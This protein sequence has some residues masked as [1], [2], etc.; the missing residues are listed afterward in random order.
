MLK[1]ATIPG[2][3]I[4]GAETQ[5]PQ[6][7]RKVA[8]RQRQLAERTNLP[9]LKEQLLRSAEKWEFLASS[10]DADLANRVTEAA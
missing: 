8:L 7:Y 4:N 2:Q 10:Q 5:W 6:R 9:Q 1:L 3:P